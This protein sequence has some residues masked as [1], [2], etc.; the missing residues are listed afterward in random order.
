MPTSVVKLQ[1]ADDAIVFAHLEIDLQAITNIFAEAYQK[2]GLIL[3]IQKIKVLH[4]QAL[5]A[6]F[7]ALAIQIHNN[8]LEDV[9]HFPYLG[10][11][12]LQTADIEEEIQY[13][14]KCASQ[15]FGHLRGCL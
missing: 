1:Y 10:S 11:H 7:Q 5:G 12:L 8:R 9:V 3:N 6:Q 13:R 4:Q 2:M 14:L 15:V